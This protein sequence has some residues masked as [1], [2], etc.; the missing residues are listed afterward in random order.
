MSDH[1]YTAPAIVLHWLIAIAVIGNVALAWAW[2][3]A[4]DEQVRPL[5]DAHKSIGI[6][7]LALALLRLLWRIG[8]RPPPHE[9][10]LARWEH[11]LAH[12]AHIGLYIVIF[13]MPITGWVMDSAWDRAAQNPNFWFGLF[14]WP[15]LGFVMALDPATKKAVHDGFGEA[16]ELF[17]KGVYLLVALHILGALKHQFMDG[18]RE[19]QRMWFGGRAG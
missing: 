11:R 3:V 2:P 8:H 10:Q 1:R 9:P 13:A 4:P 18:R 6:T 12:L 17:A 5:I 15:R 19:L 7:V 16:H 14:E